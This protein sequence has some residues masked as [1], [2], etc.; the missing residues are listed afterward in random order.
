M[1]VRPAHGTAPNAAAAP[2]DRSPEGRLLAEWPE[3]EAAPVGDGL[4]NLPPCSR[5]QELAAAAGARRRAER[6]RQELEQEVGLAH[7]EGRGWRGFHHHASLCVA[8]YGFLLAERCL[9]P[10]RRRFSAGRL[11]LPELPQGFRPRGAAPPMSPARA[12][13]GPPD[14]ATPDEAP[15]P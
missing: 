9:L 8:A 13:I 10:P 7:Y 11:A 12:A 5:P 15:G 3:H 2:E 4:S 14:P 6:D 1:G